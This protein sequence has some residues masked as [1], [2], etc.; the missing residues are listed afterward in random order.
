MWFYLSF[1]VLKFLLIWIYRENKFCMSCL[2]KLN[3]GMRKESWIVDCICVWII[4]SV[5]FVVDGELR[6]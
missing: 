5:M 4:F 2:K 6:N 1:D 3:D